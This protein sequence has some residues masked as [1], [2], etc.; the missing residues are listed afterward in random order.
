MAD[1]DCSESKRISYYGSNN[2]S[3]GADAAVG[4]FRRGVL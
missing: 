2:L 1:G 4:R 3:L